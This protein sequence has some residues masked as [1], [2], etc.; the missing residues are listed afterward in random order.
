MVPSPDLN[1]GA[2]VLMGMTVVVAPETSSMP[3]EMNR[4]TVKR[5]NTAVRPILAFVTPTFMANLPTLNQ[6]ATY[7]LPEM[8]S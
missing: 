2:G 3:V 7:I 4:V 5:I 6:Y 1:P 8:S